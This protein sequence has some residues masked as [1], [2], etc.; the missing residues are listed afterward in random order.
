MVQHAWNLVLAGVRLVSGNLHAAE[1]G[2]PAV[3]PVGPGLHLSRLFADHM[4]LQRQ[5]PV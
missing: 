2:T 1:T 5:K 4:V 3:P